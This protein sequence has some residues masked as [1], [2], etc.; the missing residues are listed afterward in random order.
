MMNLKSRT[1]ITFKFDGHRESNGRIHRNRWYGSDMAITFT[2]PKKNMN[3][4]KMLMVLK[5]GNIHSR[6]EML[7]AANLPRGYY[8][9]VFT[10]FSEMK[11]LVEHPGR[12]QWKLTKLGMKW[13]ESIKN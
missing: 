4:V 7:E 9:S 13:L 3:Y 1:G 12:D 2:N 11:S 10:A 5:D 8:S 6:A